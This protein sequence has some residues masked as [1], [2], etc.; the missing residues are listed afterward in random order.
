M[1]YTFKPGDLNWLQ[2]MPSPPDPWRPSGNV[3]SPGLSQGDYNYEGKMAQYQRDLAAWKQ[4]AGPERWDHAV[5]QGYISADGTP[6]GKQLPDSERRAPE[7]YRYRRASDTNGQT[8]VGSHGYVGNVVQGKG[9]DDPILGRMELVEDKE[10]PKETFW[11]KWAPLIAPASILAGG[12][13]IEALGLGSAGGAAA[14]AGGG[15]VPGSIYGGLGSA[16]G[17]FGTEIAGAGAA[18]AGAEGAGAAAAG[19][20]GAG[21]AGSAG[22]MTFG[23]G[24]TAGAGG[25]SSAGESAIGAF[26][27]G[28]PAAGGSLLNSAGRSLIST[29]AETLGVP[30]DV[31]AKIVSGLGATAISSILGGSGGGGS[32]GGSQTNQDNYWNN[33]HL[34][35]PN[36]TNAYGDTSEWVMD[37]ATGKYTQTQKFSA[38]RQAQYDA[39]QGIATSNAQTAQKIDLSGY[40]DPAKAYASAGANSP[41]TTKLPS[42]GG[43][44]IPWDY[45]SQIPGG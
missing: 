6:T 36:Q 5:Q 24:S 9:Y 42:M 26:G 28:G 34:Q 19:A 13:G 44:L 31:A 11:E 2:A 4:Q 43:N 15:G 33:V 25:F 22:G 23:P 37:P 29:V 12:A 8:A 10:A 35:T 20:E 16:G 45:K 30:K 17:G 38:P 39:Q 41:Y 3:D 21:S 27:G 14:G 7:G 18:A 40:S 1:A 32:G